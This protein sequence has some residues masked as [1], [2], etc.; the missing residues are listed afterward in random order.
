MQFRLAVLL[1]VLSSASI[2]TAAPMMAR[3]QASLSL[4]ASRSAQFNVSTG[5]RSLGRARVWQRASVCSHAPVRRASLCARAPVWRGAP[6]WR[7]QGQPPRARVG[8]CSLG[9]GSSLGPCSQSPRARVG[10]HP[11]GRS[12]SLGPRSPRSRVGPRS[13]W[14]GPPVGGVRARPRG[15]CA[16]GRRLRPPHSAPIPDG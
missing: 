16:L 11:L 13:F 15:A 6:H 12:S 4:F 8:P 3:Q 14:P 1:A 2:S 9:C 5:C 10:P 7:T